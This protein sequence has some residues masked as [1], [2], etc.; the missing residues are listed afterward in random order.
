MSGLLFHSPELLLALVPGPLPLHLY[1]LYT[2]LAKKRGEGLVHT[3]HAH[4][5]P[6]FWGIH[7]KWILALLL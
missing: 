5:I 7:K 4:N 3:V 2:T 1:L 6:R